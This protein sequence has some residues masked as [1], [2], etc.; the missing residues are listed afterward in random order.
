MC[1]LS[2]ID[3]ES[4]SLAENGL[5]EYGRK[6]KRGCQTD[7]NDAIGIILRIKLRIFFQVYSLLFL[8]K[9]L[10]MLKFL[11]TVHNFFIF[12]EFLYIF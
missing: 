2:V 7:R 11:K 4:V 9:L 10:K 5:H 6:G 1:L 8:K 3:Y 12:S